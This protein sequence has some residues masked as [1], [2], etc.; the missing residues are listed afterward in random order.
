M[1]S[2]YSAH[3][4]QGHLAF[5]INSVSK[6]KESHLTAAIVMLSWQGRTGRQQTLSQPR[7]KRVPKKEKG[8]YDARGTFKA[9]CD[10]RQVRKEPW[11]RDCVVP[12]PALVLDA[13]GGSLD[14]FYR[15]NWQDLL[16]Q[17]WGSQTRC[18]DPLR[19]H[20]LAVRR[21]WAM[22]VAYRGVCN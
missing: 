6:G 2:P 15:E 17:V 8:G 7:L 22:T 14:R 5:F 11:M 3:A 4:V 18:E 9:L 21:K 16:V 20:T 13:R 1:D 19:S 12:Y 10:G